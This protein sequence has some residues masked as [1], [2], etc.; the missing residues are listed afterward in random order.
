[1]KNA[2]WLAA[3]VVI[4]FATYVPQL[5]APFELQDDHRIIEPALAPHA[6]GLQM[7]LAAIAQD[8]HEVGRFR[9]V[10]QFFDVCLPLILGPRPLLWHALSLLLAIAVTVL[11]YAAALVLWRSPAAAAVF[12]LVTML[13]PDPGPAAAW[14]RLGP[15]EAWGMLLLAGALLLMVKRR[16]LWAFVLVALMALS[17]ESFLLLVPALFAVRVWLGPR[18]RKTLRNLAIAHGLL[19]AI[20]CVGILVVM[21]SAGAHSYGGQSMAVGPKA[22]AATLLRDLA[23]TPSLAVW[24]VPVLLAWWRRRRIELV[25]LVLFALWV[26]PQYL[27]YG[28]RGGFWD[29][30]W[31]PCAV[32]FAAANAAAVAALEGERWWYR[33]ALAVFAVWAINAI[34]IDVCAVQNFKLRAAVQQEAVRV[35]ARNL[36]PSSRLVVLGG[37]YEMGEI[38]SSF[39]EFVRFDGGRFRDAL[40]IDPRSKVEDA[41][42]IVNLDRKERP[43]PPG[44]ERSTLTGPQR[45]LSLRRRGWVTLPFSLSV[46]VRNR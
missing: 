34:R 10:N 38:A 40:L 39:V 5:G 30:Y 44:F 12:A 23:F 41:D 42:V 15:K 37:P 19:F 21:K 18:D 14:Y 31:L 32:A 25:H 17:K 16:D 3:A 6:G 29:H 7:W 24:F 8:V 36:R 46:D 35:A 20:G 22:I 43:V 27:L 13:A 2:L 45:F 9:P 11:L 33:A 4:V 28:T 1:M 26:G